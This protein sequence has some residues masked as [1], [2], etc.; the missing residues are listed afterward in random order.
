MV[1]K[2][3]ARRVLC[4]LL[5]AAC[6]LGLLPGR[7]YAAEDG[8]QKTVRVGWFED[9]Y[10]ITGSD[11]QRSGYG[12]EYQQSLAAYT[13]WTY[14]YVEAGWS[15]LLKMLQ[16]GQIDLMSGVSYTEERAETMLFSERPMG[17]EKYYLYA[18]VAHTNISASDLQT[19][20]GKRVGLLEGSI[21]ATQFYQWEATHGLDMAYVPVT[22]LEDAKAK[23]DAQEIDCLVSTETP[24]LVELGLSAIV[25]V[26][27][28]DIYFVINQDHPELKEALDSAMRRIQSGKPFYSDTLYQRY[29]SA[30]SASTLNQEEREWV[31]AHTPIRIGWVNGDS[32]VSDLIAKTMQLR[33]VLMDYIL[34]AADCLDNQALEFE[35]YGFNTQQEQ[36]QALQDG[37][38]DMIFHFSQNPYAAEENGFVLSDTVFSANMAAVTAKSYFDESA[39]NTVAIQK[40]D[41]RTKWTVAYNYPNWEILEY[42]SVAETEKA[43]RSGEADCLIA[44]PELLPKYIEDSKLYSFYLT[45]P[46]NCAFAVRLGEGTLVSILNKTL[47]TMSASTLTAALSMYNN[48]VQKTT[49]L[50]FVKEHLVGVAVLIVLVFLVILALLLRSQRAQAKAQELNR[51]LQSSQQELQKAL[52]KAEKA[53][54]AKT[55][56]LSNM[57][58]DIRTPMNAIVG[59]TALMEHDQDDPEKLRSYIRKVQSSSQHMLSLINDILDMSRIESDEVTL[60]QEPVS[61]ADQVGQ[62]ESILRPMVEDHGQDFTIRVHEIVHEYL[63]GDAVRLRQI[64]INL[65]SNAVKYTPYGG[66]IRFDLAEL[67]SVD[68]DYARIQVTVTDTGYGMT[69][70]FTA[71]IFEPFTRAENSTTNRIQGTGLGMAITKSIVDLMGGTITVRSEPNKG[72]RFQVTLPLRIDRSIGHVIETKGVLL[73]SDEEQLLR[74][75]SASF[76]ESGLPFYLARNREE[77]AALLPAQTIDTILLSGFL[78]DPQLPAIVTL[79]REQAQDAVLVFCVDYAQQEQVAEILNQS[80][81]NGLITR[82]F[83]FSNFAR[84]VNQARGL[85]PQAEQDTGKR[86]E[87]MKFLCAEDNALN[88]EIL[89]AILDMNGAS[90]AIYPDGKQ[91]VD[92]FASVKPGDYD[93]ILMD[94]QMPVMNGLDA[95]RAIRRGDNPLGKTIPIIAMT[96]NAFSSDVQECLDAGMNA[97]VP[98]PLDI[99]TLER[100]VQSATAASRRRQA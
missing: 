22:G 100:A 79:L 11:G 65:L 4:G 53:S 61:L 38:I 34:T 54:S 13:G 30:E 90:C 99:S 45:Q 56:F 46:D 95:T 16:N 63:I 15:D 55:T 73:I 3:A 12:Y 26:G 77:V 27:G 2:N 69:P 41:L 74:N 83:F 24:Q 84:T 97:H 1:Q 10:N 8:G 43:V 42:G 66:S 28:S 92:A 5:L 80:G 71:H 37:Q 72:S 60:N 40:D 52:T 91:L 50:G 21:Q 78:R 96:A 64:F 48:T 94:V 58:H 39:A 67:P 9:S 88:A 47:K 68:P 35:L 31:A 18:D 81:V 36:L 14:E 89:T 93:A 25:T 49:V 19:L 87:G 29:L 76:R 57:S 70:E 62:V 7:A 33:G 23:L 98:K 17:E 32:G 44:D 75:A 51:Q 59:T 82:P 20:N 86:L 85:V 6:L